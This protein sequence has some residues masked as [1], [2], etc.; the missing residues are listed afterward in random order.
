MVNNKL[1]ISLLHICI[2]KLTRGGY[3]KFIF[4]ICQF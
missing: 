4:E 2:D 3:H 1:I